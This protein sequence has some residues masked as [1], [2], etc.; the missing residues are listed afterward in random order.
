MFKRKWH[1]CGPFNSV[2][3]YKSSDPID[4]VCRQHDIGYGKLG[5]KAYFLHNKYDDRFIEDMAKQKGI[6][7]WAMAS[8]F[9]LKKQLMPAVHGYKRRSRGP[10]KSA[11]PADKRYRFSTDLTTYTPAKNSPSGSVIGTSHRGP[12]DIAKIGSLNLK[13]NSTLGKSNSMYGNRKLHKKRSRGAFKKHKKHHKKHGPKPPKYTISQ[14][15]E[16]PIKTQDLQCV[17]IGHSSFAGNEV[18]DAL[19]RS[20]V[21]AFW[22]TEGF[23]LYENTSTGPSTATVYTANYFPTRRSLAA[24]SLPSASCAASST[25]TVH[26]TAVYNLL[27]A[28][29]FAQDLEITW[30]SLSWVATVGNSINR[31][32]SMQRTI[33]SAHMRSELKVMNVTANS[34]GTD[35][36]DVTNPVPLE[37]TAYKG[38][39][40]GTEMVVRSLTDMTASYNSFL[41][42]RQHGA[43]AVPASYHTGG[44]L[45][46]PLK[47]KALVGATYAHKGKKIV[48]P[49]A[50]F[51]SVVSDSF[52]MSLAKFFRYFTYLDADTT[53]NHYC[54]RG[55]WKLYAFEKFIQTGSGTT[56]LGASTTKVE[57]D[58]EV[59]Y[60]IESHCHLK[61]LNETV[62][63]NR[64]VAPLV[65]G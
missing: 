25:F 5:N 33:V 11:Y 60:S 65:V 2:R 48:E 53:I 38:K 41:G 56:G 26:A 23:R 22:A 35:V 61:S 52:Q 34:S 15:I 55:Y 1:H 42:N 19:S 6:E 9:K 54:K 47:S 64:V 10:H 8:L 32:Y 46:E 63:I 4:E 13:K 31:D 20:I 21:R 43:I 45:D 12:H 59:N 7:P 16:A 44:A 40:N 14:R 28:M 17:Y 18:F 51:K 57:V 39:G 62:P 36:T 50:H 27:C 30:I 29:A 24:T 3:N 58:S 49:A 37:M